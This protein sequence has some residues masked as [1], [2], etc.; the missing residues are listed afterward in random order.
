MRF[1]SQH[2]YIIK[3]HAK[4]E[5]RN[6]QKWINKIVDHAMHIN[7]KKMISLKWGISARL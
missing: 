7:H 5:M 1:T 6:T 2:N 4:N 3:V